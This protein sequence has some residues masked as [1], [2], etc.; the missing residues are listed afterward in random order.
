M[1]SITASS[2]EKI[3]RWFSYV[4]IVLFFF[5]P[6]SIGMVGGNAFYLFFDFIDKSILNI[7]Q[8]ALYASIIIGYAI[9]AFMFLFIYKKNNRGIKFIRYLKIMSIAN[10]FIILFLMIVVFAFLGFLQIVV[11]NGWGTTFTQP[12]D[13]FKIN[14]FGNFYFYQAALVL[15]ALLCNSIYKSILEYDQQ[16]GNE[17]FQKTFNDDIVIKK[18]SSKRNEYVNL[19]EDLNANFS[20]IPGHMSIGELTVEYEEFSVDIVEKT[21]YL[22]DIDSRI[23][24]MALNLFMRVGIHDLEFVKSNYEVYINTDINSRI[25][26]LELSNELLSK[27]R[28]T[29][30]EYLKSN[31]NSLS[32]FH[33]L[34]N[35]NKT[36]NINPKLKYHK[37]EEV[38]FQ[39]SLFSDNGIN[40]DDKWNEIIEYFVKYIKELNAIFDKMEKEKL[41]ILV[42]TEMAKKFEEFTREATILRNS[43][44]IDELSSNT[45]TLIFSPRGVYAPYHFKY[46]D[47]DPLEID[48]DGRWHQIMDDGTKIPNDE[49]TMKINNLIVTEKNYYNKKLKANGVE[50]VVTNIDFI[51]III[52]D[53]DE[54]EITNK[55]NTIIIHDHERYE[56]VQN[57]PIIINDANLKALISIFDDGNNTDDKLSQA[58][59]INA[60]ETLMTNFI[61]YVGEIKYIS[62]NLDIAIN[63]MCKA[64]ILSNEYDEYIK[65]YETKFYGYDFMLHKAGHKYYNKDVYE[66]KLSYDSKQLES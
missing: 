49:L 23:E 34:Y 21:T 26:N 55:S 62:G 14:N 47:I 27:L 51:P 35:D 4:G 30:F 16:Q 20:Y 58:D 52:I 3:K 12:D 36:A 5:V 31:A 50:D 56:S 54:I 65:N 57:R 48:A 33:S 9:A 6:L 22:R 7:Y 66:D 28:Y 64:G 38:T 63:G 11:T 8:H 40:L 41:C 61:K 25:H 17:K 32:L 44:M 45:S 29:M 10:L 60:I 15:M 13:Y 39:R 37:F 42:N 2:R 59:Y 24:D 46:N 18:N 19:R 43:R 53:N 1:F